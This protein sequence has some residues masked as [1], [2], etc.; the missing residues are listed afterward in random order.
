[1]RGVKYRETAIELAHRG[2]IDGHRR[3]MGH[4]LSAHAFQSLYL[5]Q[6]Q[7]AL[8][9]CL[10]DGGYTVRC[11]MPGQQGWFFPCGREE[12]VAAV[13]RGLEPGETLLYLR[14]QDVSTVQRLCPGEFDFLRWPEADEY[15]YD[16]PGHI[17]LAGGD[18]ANVRTQVHKVE[19]DH[20]VRVAPLCDANTPAAMDIVRQ[21]ADNEQRFAGCAM[22]DDEVDQT[23]LREREALGL[24]GCVTWLDGVPRAVTAGFPLD[25]GTFDIVVAKHTGNTQG[26]SYY[27]KRALMQQ[28]SDR[29]LRMDLEEDLGLPGLRK[30]KQGLHPV[31]MYHIWKAVR[32]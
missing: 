4:G 1:M 13:L 9:L 15:L 18:Y 24:I 8:T 14:E 5:W 10:M 30:M 6:E 12:A 23:A 11:D 31:Q 19:R 3:A 22:R 20:A 27:A 26:L 16:I 2:L 7:M 17:A 28:V 25:E 29:F 21:W 32:K